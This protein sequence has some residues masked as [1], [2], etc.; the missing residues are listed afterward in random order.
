MTTVENR[1]ETEPNAAAMEAFGDRMAGML[2]EACAA[3]L[4]SIGHQTG[5]FDALAA[6]GLVTST[7]LAEHA[8]LNERYVREWLGGMTVA[9]MV[10]Y[11]AESDR[12][13]LPPEHAA[14]LTTAAGP[15]NLA[16]TL[17]FV[18]MLAEVEQ[19]IV[20]CFRNG[21]GLTYD[22]YPRFHALMDADSR[23]TVDATLLD[24]VLPLVDGLD[25]KL[26]AGIDVADVGC[27]SGHAINVLAAAYP[28]SR[29][30]GLDFSPVAIERARAEA[31]SLGLDNAQFEVCDVATLDRT[32]TYDLVTAFDAIHDQAHPGQVL[33]GVSR[34]L[35]P[36]GTFL[37][38]DIK[39]SSNVED[40]VGHPLAPALYTFSVLHCMTV[41][42]GLDGDGLGTVWGRQLASQMLAAAGFGQVD[43]HEVEHDPFNYYYVCRA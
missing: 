6:T 14:W 34:A 35:R 39:A 38:V 4:T 2:N 23:A 42:L 26:T 10:R 27:G 11:D 30:T 43:V 24:V 25:A 21:G 40:N 12:Y 7:E 1:T 15:N 13:F 33:A 41:S 5:L 9:R 17:Q 19:D 32:A 8:G 36:D 28:A 31:T 3:L 29:F 22:H 16:Q 18:P 37:M 20:A